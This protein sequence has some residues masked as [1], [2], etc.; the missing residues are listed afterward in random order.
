MTFPLR[1]YVTLTGCSPDVLAG[2][3]TE[4]SDF[5]A[6]DRGQDCMDLAYEGPYVD[7]DAVLDRL[8]RAVHTAGKAWVD[9]IDDQDW[10]MKRCELHADKIHVREIPL[11]EALD[12]YAF[13]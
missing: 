9:I 4:L 8:F 13:E 11:N 2:I 12:G 5:E 1:I 3:R 6:Q 7:T 10:T